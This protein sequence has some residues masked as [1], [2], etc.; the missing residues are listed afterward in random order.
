MLGV[1][2]PFV[3]FTLFKSSD[4]ML[5]YP[6]TYL[7]AMGHLAVSRRRPPAVPALAPRSPS[8]SAAA[9]RQCAADPAR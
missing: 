2:G 3:L 6:S 5:F 1:S 7:T 9:P 4:R 8:P